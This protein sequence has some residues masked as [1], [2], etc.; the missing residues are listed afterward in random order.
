MTQFNKKPSPTYLQALSALHKLMEEEGGDFVRR[1]CADVTWEDNKQIFAEREGLKEAEIPDIERL[2]GKSSD[3]KF[4]KLFE[5]SSPSFE[6][7][8]KLSEEPVLPADDHSSMWLKNGKAYSYVSQP[9]GLC[10]EDTKKLINFCDEHTLD[11][12]IKAWPSWHFPGRVLTIEVTK[13]KVKN[14]SD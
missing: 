12:S 10:L 9:Y 13:Q 14:Q 8:L 2:T 1:A 11:L 7:F 6:D 3:K 5:E 4:L